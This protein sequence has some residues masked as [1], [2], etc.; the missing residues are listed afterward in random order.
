MLTLS[1]APALACASFAAK[2]AAFLQ[3]ESALEAWRFE[4]HEEYDRT[5]LPGSLPRG[6]VFAN[7]EPLPVFTHFVERL[8][9]GG[10]PSAIEPRVVYDGNDFMILL[11]DK[12]P[13][14]D[15]YEALD[16]PRSRAGMALVHLL[17]IPKARIY[18]AVTLQAK[19]KPLLHAMQTA[20]QAL[21]Q[22]DRWRLAL[23]VRDVIADKK[24]G[25][26]AWLA[27]FDQDAAIFVNNTEPRLEFVF[28]VHGYDQAGRWTGH[29]VG[30][31]HMHCLVGPR[32]S[33]E[34]EGKNVQ[35]A[36]VYDSLE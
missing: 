23:L 19:H 1:L 7:T 13:Y 2:R 18:N 35:L 26:P 4:A 30:H 3:S 28:H 24:S 5:K 21:A 20:A 36:E 11:N 10:L 8:A 15:A 16:Q 9:K 27:K 6:G 31:L 12:M 25:N 14:A 33:M 17:A 22:V 32:T 34:D 29:S